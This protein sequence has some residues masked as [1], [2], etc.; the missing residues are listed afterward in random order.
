MGPIIPSVIILTTETPTVS[1]DKSYKEPTNKDDN[2]L[3]DKTIKHGTIYSSDDDSTKNVL[4]TPTEPTIGFYQDK[5]IIDKLNKLAMKDNSKITKKEQLTKKPHLAHKQMKQTEGFLSRKENEQLIVTV[6]EQEQLTKK[7]HLAHKRMKQT[8]EF[9]SK[10][11]NEDL[12]VTVSEQENNVNKASFT[13]D[14][15]NTDKPLTLELKNVISFGIQNLWSSEPRISRSPS[16]PMPV[17]KFNQINKV[18]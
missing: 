12:I 9:L 8:E 2:I 14:K 11:E 5:E 6:S 18:N 13:E 15:S 4:F 7:P 3:I 1:T 16:I 17:F 10:E